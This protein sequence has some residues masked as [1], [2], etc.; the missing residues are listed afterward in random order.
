ME[1]KKILRRAKGYYLAKSRFSAKRVPVTIAAAGAT[2]M[3]ATIMLLTIPYR[4]LYQGV[5]ER[6]SYQS[7]TCYLVGQGDDE[8]KLFCPLDATRNR[9]VRLDDP[10]LQ[11]SG[12]TE[13]IFAALRRVR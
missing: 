9:V 6:V 11:R 4:M 7:S 3:L 12:T 1:R 13:S 10:A 8:G 5:A 2:L